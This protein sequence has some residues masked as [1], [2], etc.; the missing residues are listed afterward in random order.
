[1][2]K[3]KN[4]YGGYKYVYK[5][6]YFGR[7]KMECAFFQH[8]SKRNLY[9]EII[10]VLS[11]NVLHVNKQSQIYKLAKIAFFKQENWHIEYY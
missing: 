11:K 3:N 5:S 1:M 2:F 9:S 4:Y 10:L 8:I 6:K 7:Q